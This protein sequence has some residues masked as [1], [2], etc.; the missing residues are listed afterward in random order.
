MPDLPPHAHLDQLRH[1]AKEL[2]RAAQGGDP[3]AAARIHAVSDRAVLASAQLA[4]AREYGFASWARLKTEV[5]RRAILNDRDVDRL[6]ALLAD[7]AGLAVTPMQRWCDHHPLGATPL[8]YVAMLRYDTS[9]DVWR[10]VTDTA[11]MARA[12]LEAGAL[13]NGA[14]DD[15]ET[16][17]ITAASYGDAAVAQVLIDAGADIHATA[18]PTSG[19]VPGG[20]ALLHAAVFGMTDVLDT[21]VAAGARPEGIASA[22]AAGDISGWLQP[23]T[24]A[25]DR[26]R[27]LIM[28]A[29]HQRLDVIDLLVDTGTS[30]DAFD[31]A[32]GRQALRVAVG[33]PASVR[34]LLAHGADPN[35]RDTDGQTA[36]D[37]CRHQRSHHPDDPGYP[38]VEA[39]LAPLT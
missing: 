32:W 15:A 11:A 28:A 26:L 23:D 13:V 39:I 16:P 8:G 10:D 20:T 2:L 5:D 34:R 33:R 1:Q 7:D 4:V 29:N 36:L 24:P 21:L 14:P 22:A 30:V 38:R 9:R 37:V 3:P 12:L 19:G 25:D 6:T 18:S 27:A 35:L 31:P 17:L